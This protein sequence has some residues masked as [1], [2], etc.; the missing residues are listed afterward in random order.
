[1]ASPP[2]AILVK[3]RKLIL[4]KFR[5][6]RIALCWK[7]SVETNGRIPFLHIWK[8][9]QMPN[10]R[11]MNYLPSFYVIVTVKT[12]QPE[13]TPTKQIISMQLMTYQGRVIAKDSVS[14]K[15][16]NPPHFKLIS[17]LANDSV[18]KVNI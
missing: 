16:T 14:W 6:L 13:G 2:E 5:F 1:M 17:Q 10:L 8:P 7:A 18:G 9:V 12:N 15:W 11:L 4:E 3:L